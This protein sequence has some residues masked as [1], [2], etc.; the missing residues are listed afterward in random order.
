M[1]S[2]ATLGFARDVRTIQNK[3]YLPRYYDPAIDERLEVLSRTHRLV[4][5]GD[6]IDDGHVTVHYGHDIGK[7]TY[8]LGSIPYVRTSD[9]ATWEIVSAPKQTIGLET[10]HDYA[11]KQDVRAGDVLFIRDG[12]YL[13]GRTALVTDA[14]LPMIHQSHLLRLRCG[15][16]S[17]ISAPL[18]MALLSTPIAVRQ[19]RSKQFTAGIIDKIEDRYREIRLPVPKNATDAT[20]LGDD[21]GRLILRR[22]ELRENLRR[23]PYVSQ[24]IT[25]DLSEPVSRT[26]SDEKVSAL[27]F[28]RSS[29]EV[30][31]SIYIPKY[32]NPTID[33]SLRS[34]R[35]DC[36]LRSIRQ[37]VDDG[38]LSVSTGIEVGKLAYGT[39]EVPF[40][41]TSDLADLELAGASKQSVS[42][43]LYEALRPRADLRPGD[44]LLVRDGTY[45]VGMSALITAADAKALFAG[46]LYNLRCNRPETLSPYLLIALLNTPIV[47]A[48]IRARQFTRDIIDTLG[49]RLMEVLLPIPRD[50]VRRLHIAEITQGLVDERVRLRNEAKQLVLGIEG[51]LDEDEQRLAQSLTL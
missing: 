36:E 38:D 16:A 31:S 19:I 30:R 29:S 15:A 11:T 44:I 26:V 40:I 50:K 17:P 39:G 37:L 27:G 14:D 47:K 48:Q 7:H 8:G 22:V 45:L 41:R 32:Y 24:G 34:L 42:E 25:R 28:T 3:I 49:W 6:L 4:R 46:G 1:V 13:I 12:L 5:L 43:E 18:L 35:A 21:I 23:L 9:L 20:S 33:E 51:S 10:Y 2:V